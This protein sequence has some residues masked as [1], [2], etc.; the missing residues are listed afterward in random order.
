MNRILPFLLIVCAPAHAELCS[1]IIN[2]T[3]RLSCFDHQSRC[4]VIESTSER[5]VCF[6]NRSHQTTLPPPPAEPPVSIAPT[7][8]PV[9]VKEIAVEAVAESETGS[10]SETVAVTETRTETETAI[11]TAEELEEAFPVRDASRGKEDKPA[12]VELNASISQVHRDGRSLAIITLDNGQVWREIK[13]SR[14]NYRE[15][16]AVTISAGVMGSNNLKADGM[17]KFVKVKRLK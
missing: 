17:K 11:A 15:G 8:E 3:E 1:A 13:K 4:A 14:F 7:E 12:P 9:R 2:D 5:L 6:D 16:L 10:E